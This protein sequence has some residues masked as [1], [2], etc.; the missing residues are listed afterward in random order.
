MPVAALAQPSSEDGRLGLRLHGRVISLGGERMA[1]GH[2]AAAVGD[3][4]A[5]ASLGTTLAEHLIAEGASSILAE[6]RAATLPVVT[7]P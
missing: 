6:V 5:A 3:E 4:A 1:E 7:E 2:V